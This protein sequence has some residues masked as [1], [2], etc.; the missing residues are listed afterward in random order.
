MSRQESRWILGHYDPAHNAIIMSRALDGADIPR[1]AVEYV[2]FHEMLHLRH[3]AEQHGHRR[4]VHT[5]AFREEERR[6]PGLAEARA[7]LKRLTAGP[8]RWW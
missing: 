3:P 1:I 4:R 7:A 5:R 8:D 6:F 2:L